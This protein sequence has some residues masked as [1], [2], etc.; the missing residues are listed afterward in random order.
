MPTG[1]VIVIVDDDESVREGTADLVKSMGFIAAAFP[2]AKGFLQS[3]Q[4]RRT[5]CLISDVRMP[6]MTGLELYDYLIGSG[7]VIPTI[8]ITAFPNDRDRVR[9]MR[10][11]VTSYL[12]KPFSE[13]ELLACIHAGLKYERSGQE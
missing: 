12:S 4:I 11:G 10:S 5:A 1:P 6:G 13:D 3:N 2:S 9:A 7:N 8:L